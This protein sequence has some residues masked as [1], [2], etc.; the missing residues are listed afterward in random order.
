M[1][2]L[3]F[4]ELLEARA[5]RYLPAGLHNTRNLAFERER[6]EAETADAKLAQEGARAATD[7]AAVVLAG[8]E[9]RNSCVFDALCCSCHN[10]LSILRETCG[11]PNDLV[12]LAL[13]YAVRNGMPNAFSKLRAPLSSFAVV[14]MVT[15]MPFSLSTFA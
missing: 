1:R 2:S 5:K 9:L 4:C 8:L 12:V 10:S 14:T 3:E 15:F 7:L 11:F 13:A 6:T